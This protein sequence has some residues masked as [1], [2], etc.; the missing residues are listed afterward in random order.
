M[1]FLATFK[2]FDQYLD[3]HAELLILGLLVIVLR[4]PNFFEPYWYGDE[5]IYLTLGNAINQ[6]RVLYEGIIDHKTPLIYYLATVPNQ[7]YFRVLM[8]FWMLFTTSIFYKLGQK[9][10]KEKKAVMASSL[11]MVILTT[12][13]WLEGNIPNGELFTMGFT[14]FGAYLFSQSKLFKNFLADKILA[15]KQGI[16]EQALIFFSGVFFSL[17]ILTKVPALLDLFAYLGVF[18]LYLVSQ[19]FNQKNSDQDVKSLFTE[20]FKRAVIF[21]AGIILPILLS[22]L[23]FASKGALQDYLDY[24]LLYNLRYS[25]SWQQDFG[26]AFSN[27][28]F[29]LL[30][31]TIY[32]LVFVLLLFFNSRSLDKKYQLISLWFVATLYSVLLSS[33]PYPHYFI[34]MVPAFS[35]LI[36]KMSLSG[37]EILL[38]IKKKKM[39]INDVKVFFSASF[40]LLITFYILIVFNFGTYS[41][42]SYY[43][44]FFA[45]ASGQIDRQ[46]YENKFDHFIADNRIASQIIKEMGVKEIFIWGTNPL[47]YAQSGALPTSRF[48]VSF[49]IKDFNDFQ[50]TFAQIE[51]TAPK[52]I[53][54]MNNENDD[55]PQLSNYLK[56]YYSPNSQLQTMTLYLR[57]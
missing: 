26:S 32:L 37:K 35:L 43:K 3:K 16:K 1:N 42:A 9:F 54:V 20:L 31:K 24:G 33:R 57:K 28:S 38:Q 23:Y 44:N 4:I 55:F 29:S 15:R 25:Q 18:F 53:I 47:L 8:L 41:A 2:K 5:A 6:G 50:T 22:I 12:M 48:T 27:F 19:F 45:F 30:G 21:A 51:A 7:F 39:L 40:L 11:I 56:E 36:V 17:G 34:Q 49:H 52:L 14:L 10:F 13:P 46:T